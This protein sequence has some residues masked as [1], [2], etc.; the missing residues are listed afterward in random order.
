MVV[1]AIILGKLYYLVM[2][3]ANLDLLRYFNVVALKLTDGMVPASSDNYENNELMTYVEARK[4]T[5][6]KT[7]HHCSNYIQRF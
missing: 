6:K 4:S 7:L 1:R 5:N 2:K 3:K